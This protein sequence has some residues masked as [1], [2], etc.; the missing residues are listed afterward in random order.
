LG[1]EFIDT[2]ETY[3]GSEDVIAQALY[4]YPPQVLIA[5]KGGLEREGPEHGEFTPWPRNASPDQLRRGCESSLRRLRMDCI[6]LYQLH[7]PDPKVPL[8]ESLE[9]L[10]ELQ[11]EG[12]IRHLGISNVNCDELE[13]ALG[14]ATIVSVQNSYSVANREH[15]EVLRRCEQ[16]GLAFIAWH[17]LGDGHLLH[18]TPLLSEIARRH[19]ATPSQ[20]AITWLL[21]HSPRL[22]AIPGTCSIAHLEENLGAAELEL[23][24]DDIARLDALA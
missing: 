16:E 15:E 2:A 24:H 1:V 9:A 10:A 4:P 22:V 23:E 8:P 12:K 19:G 5:T 3:G 21:Q 17:P 18:S 6:D 7:S 14:C 11:R 20:V 13:V